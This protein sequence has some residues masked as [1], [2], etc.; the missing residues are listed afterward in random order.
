MKMNKLMELAYQIHGLPFKG[1]VINVKD[2]EQEMTWHIL[3]VF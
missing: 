2:N 1:T 3:Y